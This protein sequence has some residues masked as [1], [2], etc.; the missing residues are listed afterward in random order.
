MKT[1]LIYNPNAGN[2]QFPQKLDY[3]IDRF[4]EAGQ[5]VYPYRLNHLKDLQPMLETLDRN[6]YGKVVLAGGDGTIHQCIN[7][8]LQTGWNLP[9][10]IYPAGTANDFCQNFNLPKNIEEMTEILI[11]DNYT[12]C[13]I[14]QANEQYFINVA[15]LGFLI[16]ISQRTDPRMKNNLGVLAYYMKGI[17][18]LPNMKPVKVRL[19]IAG[20][21]QEIEI[22]FILVMNGQS[23]GGFKR[24]AP[25]ATVCDGLLDVFVF[26]KCP[27]LELMPLLIQIMN[28]DHI[29]SNYVDFFQ[30]DRLLIECKDGV[31][32]DL[33]GENGTGFPMD[34][35]VRHHALKI[36]TLQNMEEP[37]SDNNSIS[38]Y[39]FKKV[40]SGVSK[41][42]MQS[43][44]MPLL[45]TQIGLNTAV[46]ITELVKDLPKHNTL[47]YVNQKTLSETYFMSAEKSLD[48]GYLYIILSSTGSPAG[49]LI[50]KVTQKEYS[51][52][53]LSFD[54]D[55]KTIISY[56]GGDNIY[57]PGLNAEMIEFFNKKPDANI[58]IYKLPATRQ[59]K[60]QVLEA[61]SGINEK[62]S[63]YNVLGLFLPYSHQENIMFCS[64]FVYTMLKICGLDYFEKKPEEVK[65][66]D[67]VE[68]DY[69]RVL[70]YC[71]QI[72]LKD[73][74]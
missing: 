33:D 68:L 34:I 55:L 7:A 45:N 9:V 28:G 16:D 62:G 14:G 41:T 69:Q 43:I 74:L 57:S 42:V 51:H 15:S 4:Q 72:F 2:G 13:D 70:E 65:P 37:A 25:Q 26:K 52:A 49:E 10:G 58:L 24:I 73:R 17:E 27:L 46:N 6:D 39:D 59:Q 11:R 36:I 38:L 23:A 22:F 31:G 18:E 19:D 54:E 44:N 1:L 5:P 47:S 12:L 21:R 61:I 20:S 64:Q 35:R 71:G 48:N 40:L 8:L 66:T 67:F 63:S 60:E 30:T 32:T 3:I 50:R 29:K 53:S 56:N